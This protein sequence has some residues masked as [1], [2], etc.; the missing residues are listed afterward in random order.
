MESLQK[1]GLIHNHLVIC[2]IAFLAAGR[3]MMYYN[4]YHKTNVCYLITIHKQ[5]SIAHG[6]I[7]TKSDVSTLPIVIVFSVVVWLCSL[8]HIISL[9]AYTFRKNRDFVFIIIVQ[10]MISANNQIRFGLRI[11]FV[12][13]YITPSHYHHWANSSVDIEIIKRLSDTFRRVCE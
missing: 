5:R 1:R 9:I 8:H 4:W 10:F 7:I 11:V 2:V 3:D 6:I 13:L 12:C